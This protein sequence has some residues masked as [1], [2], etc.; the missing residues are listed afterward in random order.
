MNIDDSIYMEA[1]TAKKLHAIERDWKA[2][3]E[4]AGIRA[5][6]TEAE[7]D[8]ALA[9]VEAILDRTRNRSERE[10]MTYP[11]NELLAFLAPA[12]EAYEGEL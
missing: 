10:D 1:I 4:T 6:R 8:R 3:S 5:L 12:I 9:L 2:F 7:Y 11:L